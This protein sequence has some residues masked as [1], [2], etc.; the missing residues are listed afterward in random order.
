MKEGK[1][2]EEG[3]EREDEERLGQ[4]YSPVGKKNYTWERWD[5][6]YYRNQKPT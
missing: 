6:K 1:A 3:D 4:D 2:E 5:I